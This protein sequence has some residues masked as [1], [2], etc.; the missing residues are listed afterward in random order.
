[1]LTAKADISSK[2][3]GFERG[4]DAYLMKP[5]NK[6]EL[7]LRIKKLLEL[8]QQLQQFYL[9]TAGLKM[10]TK[11]VSAEG[12]EATPYLNSFDNVFVIKVKTIIEKHINDAD[13]DIEK[14][15]RALALSV[16]QVN[17]KLTALT[18]FSTNNFM[19]YV[20]LIK[21]KELLLHSGYSVT[22]I[23]YDSGFNDP[24]YFIRVFKQAFG[25]TPQVW[26]EQHVE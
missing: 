2:L 17:R 12:E 10:G 18:G 5:F 26:R 20:R 16:S 22:A 15:A 25:V 21:S 8:R 7:L 11:A 6:E 4:A 14:L 13:F 23:A 19:R 24:A 9:S 3:Q 1:L